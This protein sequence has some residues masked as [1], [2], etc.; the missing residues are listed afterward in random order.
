MKH[1]LIIAILTLTSVALS[2]PAL[3]GF[4]GATNQTVLS[5]N[6]N[7]GFYLLT[8]EG[9]LDIEAPC[10]GDGPYQLEI[11]EHPAY[12]ESLLIYAFDDYGRIFAFSDSVWS[13]PMELQEPTQPGFCCDIFTVR[14]TGVSII[15]VDGEG[16]IRLSAGKTWDLSF[17]PFTL[18]PPRETVALYD[19]L[20]TTLAPFILG[21]DGKIYFFVNN[22]WLPLVNLEA[23]HVIDFDCFMHPTTGEIFLMAID[24]EGFIYD[25][26]SGEFVISNLSEYPGEGPFDLKIIFS[27]EGIYDILCIDSTGNLF[28]ANTDN[29]W[30]WLSTGF[31]Q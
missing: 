19:T 4:H 1:I 21:E 12:P 18:A 5:L 2:Q 29:T 25:N 10:P 9:W 30:Y 27:N 22:E 11:V 3:A 17:Q 31:N 6:E 13:P 26:F 7:G 8:T 28:I 23:I 16:N 20:T 24:N 14:E 15:L